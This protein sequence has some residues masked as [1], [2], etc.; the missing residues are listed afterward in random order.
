MN[1][2]PIVKLQSLDKITARTMVF[3]ARVGSAIKFGP[4]YIKIQSC[5][6]APPIEKPEAA[7]FLQIWEN[8]PPDSKAQWIFSGWMFASSPALSAMDHP[9]YDVWVIDC[10]DA[11][12]PPSS[13]ADIAGKKESAAEE[14]VE[15][16]T[17]SEG[18]SGEGESGDD[19]PH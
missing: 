11:P 19:V 17:D 8:V 7:A 9:V 12:S 14:E 15:S 16:V 6:K 10:L 4:I 1:D 18:E 13:K 2:Y 3:E 5:R